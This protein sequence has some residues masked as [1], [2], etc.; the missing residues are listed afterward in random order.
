[1]PVGGDS[2]QLNGDIQ[3]YPTRS[4]TIPTWVDPSFN[5][6]P[7]VADAE[8]P[9]GGGGG[10]WMPGEG[11]IAEPRLFAYCELLMSPKS[12]PPLLSESYT[13]LLPLT[14]TPGEPRAGLSKNFSFGSELKT[15]VPAV[16]VVPDGL[17]ITMS[18]DWNVVPPATL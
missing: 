13:T 5:Q 7:L 16:S 1:M 2:A 3:L 12:Y 17:E 9:P 6:Q 4:A 10:M 18:V 11:T 14:Q 8:H 15:V